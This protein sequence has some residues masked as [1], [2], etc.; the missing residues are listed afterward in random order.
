MRRRDFLSILGAAAAACPLAVRAQQ[1][2][3]V[4]RIGYLS[5]RDLPSDTSRSFIQGLSELGYVEGKNLIVEYRTANGNTEQLRQL[6][7]EL[8][9]AR[10]D[11]I[12]TEGTPPTKAACKPRAQFP[13]SLGPLKTPSR[14]GSLPV[15][16]ALVAM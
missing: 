7:A 16:A 12:A 10:V 2:G 8:V 6:A 11:L 4:W 3:K 5:V 15:W 13:S 14:R 1:M 9:D